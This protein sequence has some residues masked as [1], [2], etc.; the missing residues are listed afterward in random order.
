MMDDELHAV[1][2]ITLDSSSPRYY[3]PEAG[4]SVPRHSVVYTANDLDLADHELVIENLVTG[5]F[6]LDYVVYA[7]TG[8]LSTSQTASVVSPSAQPSGG[9]S[10][11]MGPQTGIQPTDNSSQSIKPPVSA[12]VGGVIGGIAL[13]ALLGALCFFL[14]RWRRAQSSDQGTVD[15]LVRGRK[16][17]TFSLGHFTP[18]TESTPYNPFRESRD[19]PASQRHLLPNPDNPFIIPPDNQLLLTNDSGS[20]GAR[21]LDSKGGRSPSSP[22]TPQS[23]EIRHANEVMIPMMDLPRSSNTSPR[24]AG[25]SGLSRFTLLQTPS[26]RTRS[27]PDENQNQAQTDSSPN[28]QQTFSSPSNYTTTL[29]GWTSSPPP[30]YHDLR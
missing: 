5:P 29:S 13:L 8:S 3:R 10:S 21:P 11:T 23:Q 15:K 26:E 25:S 24:S 18:Y 7:T 17:K 4:D 9:S 6:Y 28:T 2:N 27:R 19:T 30:A 20:P 12:I 1:L 14:G 22:M 16:S